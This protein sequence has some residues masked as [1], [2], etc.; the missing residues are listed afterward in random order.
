MIKEICPLL[1][2]K[3]QKVDVCSP[4]H[5]FPNNNQPINKVLPLKKKLNFE[6]V[7]SLDEIL[8]DL[9]KEKCENANKNKVKK[10][11]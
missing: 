3:N 1:P 6:N 11:N 5:D 2:P 10:T 4:Y 9:D 7:K 8:Q